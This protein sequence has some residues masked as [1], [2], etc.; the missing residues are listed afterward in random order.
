MNAAP[1]TAPSEPSTMPPSKEKPAVS[2]PAP[3]KADSVG[4]TA[5]PNHHRVVRPEPPVQTS[6]RPQSLPEQPKRVVPQRLHSPV[7]ARDA[8]PQ[9]A[10]SA[11]PNLQPYPVFAERLPPISQTPADRIIDNIVRIVGT[12]GPLTGWRLHQVY[13]KC[14]TGR[15]PHDEFSRLLNRAISAAERHQ[16]IVSE[17]P[18]NQSGNKPRTFR[19]RNQSSTVAREL[20]PRTIDIVPPSEV[21]QYCRKVSAGQ[22]LSAGELAERVGR[23]LRNKQVMNDLQNAVL[24]ANRIDLESAGA[25]SGDAVCP[26]C[27]TIHA[28]ECA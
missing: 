26:S 2:R 11:P 6:D 13:R 7:P 28:G 3:T 17:N 10:G 18:L 19:L 4:P 22:S 8:L 15:E 12:E 14:A 5:S 21:L 1:K 9:T 27:F 20:G 16:R 25:R 24:A 23:L